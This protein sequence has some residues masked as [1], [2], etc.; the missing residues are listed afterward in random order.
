MRRGGI[1]II[2]PGI[3]SF[4][5]PVLQ[6]MKKGV[7]GFQ[8]V[9]LL[10][11]AEEVGVVPAWNLLA[12]FPGESP[13]E[14]DRMAELLPLLTHLEPPT[15]CSPIR[16]DRFSPLFNDAEASGLRRVRPT[17]A[18]YYVFPFG[19]RELERLAYFFDFDYADGRKPETYVRNLQAAVTRWRDARFAG[20][21]GTAP[22]HRLDACFDAHGVTVTD[23]RA[24]AV[25]AEQQLTGVAADVLEACDSAHR[26]P[27]LVRLLAAQG[28]AAVDVELA[29]AR[30]LEAKL[31][32]LLDDHV[33][34]LPV[35]RRRR[36]ADKVRTNVIPLLNQAPHSE[37]LL[38]LR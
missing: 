26:L 33:L 22:V 27:A 18:Y 13:A 25:A 10:R 3:E 29:V 31:T 38:H 30:L 7:T 32:T 15:G 34:S 4:S 20:E 21:A 37:Q 14:Y 1:T 8:N 23:S 17:L 12:G 16:L 36:I 11:W 35:F 28:H 24:C 2:Q 9:Q 19:R 5:S 6:L